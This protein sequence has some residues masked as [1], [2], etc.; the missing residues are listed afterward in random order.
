[1]K[2]DWG[3]SHEEGHTSERIANITKRIMKKVEE[4]SV[5]CLLGSP[6]F[7]RFLYLTD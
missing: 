5:D 6:V 4:G 1:M 7:E 2:I 3:F